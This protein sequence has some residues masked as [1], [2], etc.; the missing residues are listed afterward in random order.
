[1]ENKVG[2]IQETEGDSL[3]LIG[4]EDGERPKK[5]KKKKRKKVSIHQGVDPVN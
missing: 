4:V 2:A 5:L 1:V 3:V